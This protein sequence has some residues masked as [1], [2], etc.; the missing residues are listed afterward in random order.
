VVPAD[1]AAAAAAL[2]ER[3]QAA[4]VAAPAAMSAVDETRL[5]DLA[6]RERQLQKREEDMAS[7]ERELMEQRRVLAEQYRL[8][9]SHPLEAKPAGAVQAPAQSP[10][11]PAVSAAAWPPAP[12][13]QTPNFM[14]HPPRRSS[15]WR[16]VKHT[17]L[18]TPEPVLE[19]SL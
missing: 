9:R 7:R 16:R 8:L 18:G 11:Q 15:F 5:R 3:A 10:A 4:A 6:E 19:D 13:I 17:F 1:P 2:R 14:F 12:R